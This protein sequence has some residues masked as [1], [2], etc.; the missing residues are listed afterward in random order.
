MFP[1]VATLPPEPNY[2]L[3]WADEFNRDGAPDPANWVYE[4]GFVRNRELQWY[5][6]QNARVEKGRLIIEGRRERVKNPDYGKDTPSWKLN[7]E[8]AEY[9][10]A[11]IET[12]GLHAWKFGRIEV[13]AKIDARPGLWPAIWTLGVENPWPRCGEV[14]VMEFYQNT[15]LANT[16]WS[17]GT[18]NTQKVP[19]DE[20]L[21]KDK[22]WGK[23]WHVW[24]M[25]WDEDFIRITLDGRLMNE[26]DLSKTLNKDGFNPFHQPH[27]LILNLAIGSTGGDPSNTIFPARYEVDYVRVYQ[28]A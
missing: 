2:K 20:F 22:N 28:K 21:K 19:Y 12:R 16:C 24:R 26:T 14:D 7:T 5:Q 15:I 17:D 4:T 10:S 9:T 1:L 23:K 27:Y 3:V 18:W 6:P 11:A 25:D 8:Y 13:R